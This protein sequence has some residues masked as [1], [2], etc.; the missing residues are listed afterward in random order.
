MPSMMSFITCEP[1]SNVPTQPRSTQ[2]QGFTSRRTRKSDT[3]CQLPGGRMA[4]KRVTSS[5]PLFALREL[6][7]SP[8]A[9][10]RMGKNAR[11]TLKATACET[12]PHCGMILARVRNSFSAM[13]RSA[14]VGDYTVHDNFSPFGLNGLQPAGK[15]FLVLRGA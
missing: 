3:S 6:L 14:I 12:M 15:V 7:I 2:F 4:D 1:T 8:T 5:W 10:N 9:I 13:E 11:N